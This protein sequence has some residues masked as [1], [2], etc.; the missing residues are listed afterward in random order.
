MTLTAS[1]IAELI[2]ELAEVAE[3]GGADESLIRRASHA[4]RD[5]MRQPTDS[6]LAQADAALTKIKEGLRFSLIAQ[7]N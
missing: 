1:Q 2:A 6:E 3:A 5:L 7:S 4:A